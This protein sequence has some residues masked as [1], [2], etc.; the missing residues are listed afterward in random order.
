M[1][2]GGAAVDRY[3]AALWPS[4][5]S[6]MAW[7]LDCV[8]EVEM[9]GFVYNARYIG[10]GACACS[11]SAKDRTFSGNL[12]AEGNAMRTAQMWPECE[13]PVMIATSLHP[14]TSMQK[15]IQQFQHGLDIQHR[16]IVNTLFEF[17]P[18]IDA[19]LGTIA[20]LCRA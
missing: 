17:V 10:A 13:V 9:L 3:E 14:E 18:S 15:D 8:F 2:N 19:W 5:S 6:E 16:R 20:V 7:N 1:Q 4:T 12:A 11:F